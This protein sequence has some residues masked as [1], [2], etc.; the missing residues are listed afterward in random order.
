MPKKIPLEIIS[1]SEQLNRIDTQPLVLKLV[2]CIDKC[3]LLLEEKD[4]R[5]RDQKHSKSDKEI[6]LG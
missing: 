5:I 6:Y 4:K 1:D 2:V 3:I